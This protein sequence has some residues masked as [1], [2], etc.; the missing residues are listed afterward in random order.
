MKNSIHIIVAFLM[1]SAATV[2]AQT[3]SLLNS[4]KS[5]DNSW[6]GDKEL[7]K[8]SKENEKRNK[9]TEKKIAKAEHKHL[10]QKEQRVGANKK[11]YG[12]KESRRYFSTNRYDKKSDK[13]MYKTK[14]I[15]GSNR[16]PRING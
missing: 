15:S 13:I 2:K 12:T 11:T 10:K 7:K 16:R 6:I 5:N 9:A 4:K 8:R 3:L 14:D 1:I